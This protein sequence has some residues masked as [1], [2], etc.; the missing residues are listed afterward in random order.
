MVFGLE[1]RRTVRIVAEPTARSAH[2]NRY[3]QRVVGG[4]VGH[5]FASDTQSGENYRIKVLS[6]ALLDRGADRNSG[7]RSGNFLP[8]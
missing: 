5:P 8:R 3:T 1:S 6:T 2:L 4:C 7:G